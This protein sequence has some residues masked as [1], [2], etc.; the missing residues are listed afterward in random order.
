MIQA[1]LFDQDEGDV[2]KTIAKLIYEFYCLNVRVCAGDIVSAK[3]ALPLS[4]KICKEYVRNL[5]K[6]GAAY[7]EISPFVSG[8]GY[9]GVLYS[10]RFNGKIKT[11]SVTPRPME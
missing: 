8:G 5:T 1:D 7:V 11:L 6:D 4:F 2:T 9:V 10:Y 3:A